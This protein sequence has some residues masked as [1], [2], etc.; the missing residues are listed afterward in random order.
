MMPCAA[1]QSATVMLASRLPCIHCSQG[2]ES[3][4]CVQSSPKRNNGCKPL[5]CTSPRQ[6]AGTAGISSVSVTVAL[7]SASMHCGMPTLPGL[8]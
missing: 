6:W 1:A 5:S 8:P 4:L 3:S 2:A 7:T